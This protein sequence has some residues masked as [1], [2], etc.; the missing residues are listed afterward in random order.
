MKQLVITL[1]TVIVLLIAS[2]ACSL[3]NKQ[4]EVGNEIEFDIS[5]IYFEGHS[6]LVFGEYEK[7]INVVHNPNCNCYNK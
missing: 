3:V 5:E 7:T 4:K 1:S 2:Y 6:Y